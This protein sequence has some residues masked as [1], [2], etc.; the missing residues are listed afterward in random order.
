MKFTVS[1]TA[2]FSRLTALSRV[3]N[4]KNSL[5]I[6]DCYLFEITGR[7]LTI[8]ASDSETTLVS[9]LELADCDQDG[10]FCIKAKTIH[11][12][13]KMIA[14]QPIT[15]NVNMDTMEIGGTYQNGRFS[16]IGERAD[17]YPT[18]HQASDVEYKFAIKESALLAGISY[19]LF[20]TADD[21]LRPVMTGIYFDFTPDCLV[22][23]GTDG[24]KLVR[25]KEYSIKSTEPMGFILPKKP[26]TVL[27]GLLQKNDED[28]QLTFTDKLAIVKT[29][30]FTLTT[31]LIDGRY[32]VYNAVIPVNNPFRATLDRAVFISTLRRIIVFSSASSSM[33]KLVFTKDMLTVSGQDV[34]FSTSAEEHLMCEYDGPELKIGFKGTL[35]IDILNNLESDEVVLA[36]AD[37]SRAGLI[38]PA[39]Q[40]ESSEVLMLLMPL[41]LN[42]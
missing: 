27:K 36:M 2:L 12:S 30:E 4:S 14:D 23:V 28:I 10:R 13:I 3:F 15:L 25:C 7:N 20:A 39:T 41:M 35:L 42:D 18:T 11:D 1:S 19:S 33:V 6:L 9:N 17:D 24:R 5:P 22:F 38:T 37:S 32:P 31:R 34:D 29:S 16:I 8:T 26:A 40:N 21:G